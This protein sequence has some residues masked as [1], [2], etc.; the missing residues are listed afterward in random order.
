MPNKSQELISLFHL[1]CFSPGCSPLSLPPRSFFLF[2]PLFCFHMNPTFHFP[3]PRS[4]SLSPPLTVLLEHAAGKW[5]MITCHSLFI[6]I[7][8]INYTSLMLVVPLEIYMLGT[9]QCENGISF[10]KCLSVGTAWWLQSGCF[11]SCVCLTMSSLTACH[12]SHCSEAL[13][14]AFCRLRLSEDKD[15]AKATVLRASRQGR[16]ESRH[17]APAPITCLCFHWCE[18]LYPLHLLFF[19]GWLPCMKG[20]LHWQAGLWQGEKLLMQLNNPRTAS[21][22]IRSK[23]L[24]INETKGKTKKSL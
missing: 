2:P 6:I 7:Q 3:R 22:L 9:D 4:S 1:S 21:D 16:S 24:Q 13:F 15:V 5:W 8:T 14:I 18:S 12:R 10:A 23:E 20:L 17:T 11:N 19:Y